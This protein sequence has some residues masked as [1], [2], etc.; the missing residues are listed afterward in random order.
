MEQYTEFQRL[1]DWNNNPRRIRICSF[2]GNA[3]NRQFSSWPCS[4]SSGGGQYTKAAQRGYNGELRRWCQVFLMFRIWFPR[5]PCVIKSLSTFNETAEEKQTVYV[6][7]TGL[8][9]MNKLW[10][11]EKVWFSS[12]PKLAHRTPAEPGFKSL[13]THDTLTQV[14]PLNLTD[15]TFSGLC[16]HDRA[17]VALFFFFFAPVREGQHPPLSFLKPQF[18]PDKLVEK[19]KQFRKGQVSFEA[20][21]TRWFLF[22]GC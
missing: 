19:K 21:T 2:N 3:V 13:H 10:K 17:C 15:Q 20:L 18:A 1:Y 5:D 12:P 14:P 8:N 7:R 6:L 22:L 16:R 9:S 4:S 11:A